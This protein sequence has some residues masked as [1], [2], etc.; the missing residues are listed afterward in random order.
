MRHRG[1]IRW[2]RIRHNVHKA[3]D[4]LGAEIAQIVHVFGPDGGSMGW[5]VYLIGDYG[6]LDGLHAGVDAAKAAAERALRARFD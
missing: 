4:P 1:E 2:E 6:P 5:S 3:Y